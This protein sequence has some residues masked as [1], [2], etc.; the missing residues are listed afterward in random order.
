CGNDGLSSRPVS[1]SAIGR[2]SVHRVIHP[3]PTTLL[4][5]ERGLDS[6]SVSE[7]GAGFSAEGQEGGSV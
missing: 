3:H 6:G 2:L 5:R 1:G 7:Y 4:S